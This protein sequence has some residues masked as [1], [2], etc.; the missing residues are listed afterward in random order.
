MANIRKETNRHDWFETILKQGP[1]NIEGVICLNCR[2]PLYDRNADRPVTGCLSGVK[3]GRA[4][5]MFMT[6][7]AENSRFGRGPIRSSMTKVSCCMDLD[8]CMRRT[9]TG[10]GQPGAKGRIWPGIRPHRAP[11]THP[12]GA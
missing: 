3:V 6:L 9:R 8:S 1:Y 10:N 12:E 4:S 7:T 11:A 5:L 2:I